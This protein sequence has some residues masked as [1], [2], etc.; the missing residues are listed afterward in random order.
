MCTTSWSWATFGARFKTWSRLHAFRR[1]GTIPVVLPR[2]LNVALLV[3]CSVV[4]VA[5]ETD[6]A[7]PKLILGFEKAE[8][9]RGLPVSYEEK[10]GRD[11]WFFLLDRPEGFDFA[12][13]FEWP[14]EVNR[15]W[16]WRCRSGLHTE[17]KLALAATVGP[18]SR[19]PPG[20]AAPASGNLSH[21]YPNMRAR[22]EAYSLMTTFEWL[23]LADPSLRNWSGYD[24]LWVDVRCDDAPVHVW[25]ALEDDVVEPPVMR[26]YQ[27][28]RGEWVTLELDLKEAERAREIDLAKIANFWLLGRAPV[29]TQIRIDNVRIAQRG[30]SPPARL[31][32]DA[33][34]MAF[35]LSL[36]GA[37]R[38]QMPSLPPDLKPARG[39]V[40]ASASTVVARGSVVPFGWVAAYDSKHLMVAY[41]ATE[42][43]EK[44]TPRAVFTRDGGQSW[45]P[46]PAPSA[47]NLDHGTA[48]GGAIGAVGD[49][50]AV[51]SGPG[52]AGLG[53]PTPR[54][55]LT[56]YTFNGSGWRVEPTAILDADIRHCGS[57]VSVVR[58]R[59]GAHRGRLWASWGA[60]DR[61]HRV[62]VHVKYSDDDGRTWVP[63]G[64]GAA[65]PDSTAGNWS[66]A[67]YGYPETVITPYGDHVACFWRHKRDC[68]VLW[69][70]Y[71]GAE[72]SLPNEV[73]PV[74]LN[75]MDG[76]YRAT[77]SAVTRGDREVFFT[78]TGFKTVLRWDGNAWVPAA[79]ECADGGMLSLSGD[80]VMLFT[81]GR[82][83]R[84]WQGVDWSRETTL[85]CF[86][87]RPDGHWQGPRDLTG[88]VTVHEY[89][90]MAGF[91]VP[92]YSPPDYVPLVW[93]D[94]SKG[95]VQLL[96]V[97]SR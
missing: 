44:P 77:M 83:G 73:A 78:A 10:P 86:Q 4:A 29:R 22:A 87:C 51:S 31:L 80:V 60:L 79:I 28:P 95:T 68:G 14:G 47:R 7:E 41:S 6:V 32:R 66:N 62:G 67:T 52:C 72:W 74:T 55:H 3:L 69:S 26:T 21:Y 39:P 40:G 11:H 61:A 2:V 17:G 30:T 38:P 49:G 91:S 36:A 85:R 71:D 75:D 43:G 63:W 82:V 57:N 12:A 94:H 46:L 19:R 92:P 64:K 35:S 93:S 27:V 70:V 5:A 90:A 16:T 65:L 8:L 23:T 58:L 37:D 34:S 24:M 50:V 76:S 97:S 56:K 20:T 54:Q 96:K 81:A 45:Q 33:S 53:H 18:V 15:A 59:R 13:R 9:S 88:V 42:P 89:R 25:L 48:R 84:R 1:E